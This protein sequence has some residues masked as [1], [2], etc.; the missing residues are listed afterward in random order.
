MNPREWPG[1]PVAAALVVLLGITALAPSADVA[2]GPADELPV[3]QARLVCPAL[4]ASLPGAA[5]ALDAAP[6]ADAA[7]PAPIPPGDTTGSLTMSALTAPPG[8]PP[9]ASA[10]DLGRPL[11][12]AIAGSD[13][14]VDAA[15][16]AAAGLVASHLE[17]QP[18]G[19]ARA[20]AGGGCAA[21]AVQA[22]YVGGGGAVGQ[23]STLFLANA[24]AAPATVE[25]A[26]WSDTGP[27]SADR[28]TIVTVPARGRSEVALD[29]LAPGAA[30]VAVSVRAVTGR[31]SSAVLDRRVEGTSPRGADWITAGALARALVVGPLPAAEGGARLLQLT[32]PGDRDAVVQVRVVTPDGAFAPAGAEVLEVPA[33]TVAEVDVTAFAEGREVA[34]ELDSDVPI[35]AT[36]RLVRPGEGGITEE[37]FVSGVRPADEPAPLA[38]AEARLAPDLVS[39]LLVTAPDNAFRGTLRLIP[40]DPALQ[41]LSSPIEVAAGTTAAVPLIPPAPGSFSVVL[42]PATGSGPAEAVRWMV[43][44]LAKGPAITAQRLDRVVTAVPAPWTAPDLGAGL[45]G[46]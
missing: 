46:H 32:A 25:V 15:G 24:E 28:P 16:P 35:A 36:A 3:E 21:A 8:T 19:A 42:E 17:A 9:V 38:V 44:A 6:S 26:A 11:V 23:R 4:D 29:G 10:A 39:T 18:E 27:V 33:G 45:P 7:A 5:T 13:L 40:A 2:A 43:W 12:V 31:V 14:L 30:R 34:I 20:L 37:A 22:W 41:P 1:L